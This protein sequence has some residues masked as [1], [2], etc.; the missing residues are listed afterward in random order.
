MRSPSSF[1]FPHS[2]DHYTVAF[3][4]DTSGAKTPTYTISTS[5]AKA[6]VQ[7]A[8]AKVVTSYAQNN[9]VVTH[10]IY[11]QS[12]TVHDAIRPEHRIVYDGLNYAYV[13]KENPCELGRVYR[14]DVITE[15]D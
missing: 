14:I 1:L 8:G 12:S 3:A 4:K 13:G 9:E 2:I 15:T 10:S 11:L 7:P 5:G 6:F